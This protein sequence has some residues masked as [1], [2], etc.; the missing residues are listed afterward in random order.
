MP[1]Y[2]EEIIIPLGRGCIA[3]L[4]PEEAAGLLAQHPELWEKA[5]KRGK[6]RRRSE[7]D[8]DRQARPRRNVF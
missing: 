5:V 2:R 3:I 6:W 8:Y 4:T 7:R 1:R